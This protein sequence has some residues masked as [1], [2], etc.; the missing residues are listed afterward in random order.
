[1]SLSP[2]ASQ[3]HSANSLKVLSFLCLST[4]LCKIINKVMHLLTNVVCSVRVSLG[5][6]YIKSRSLQE[7]D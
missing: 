1:M 3:S 2:Q 4:I 5:R 6:L 7:N